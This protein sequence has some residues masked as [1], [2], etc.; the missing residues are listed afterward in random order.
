MAQRRHPDRA[1]VAQW[2]GSGVVVLLAACARCVVG[3]LPALKR[4]LGAAGELP[5]VPGAD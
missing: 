2:A 1:R 4:W 5:E 3:R